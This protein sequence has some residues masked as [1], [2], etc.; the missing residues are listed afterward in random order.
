MRPVRLA[1][2]RG[3]SL[4]LCTRLFS[5]LNCPRSVERNPAVVPHEVA[6]KEVQ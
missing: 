6:A 4:T 1:R 2:R 3:R 5:R